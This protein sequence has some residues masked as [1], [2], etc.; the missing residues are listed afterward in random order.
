MPTFLLAR[1]LR[2]RLLAAGYPV[3]CVTHARYYFMVIYDLG[4]DTEMHHKMG[5]N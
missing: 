5:L 2:Y 4:E 1:L 3:C